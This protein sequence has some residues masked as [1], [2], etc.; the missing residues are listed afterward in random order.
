MTINFFIYNNE[1]VLE[2]NV[3]ELGQNNSI[4]STVMGNL[5]ND[6]LTKNY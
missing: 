6:M 1:N 2:F 4:V 3:E 5:I